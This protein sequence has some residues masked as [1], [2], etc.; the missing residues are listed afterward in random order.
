LQDDFNLFAL[1]YIAQGKEKEKEHQTQEISGKK[2]RG[3][4]Q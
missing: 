3:T 1:T 4:I 2:G